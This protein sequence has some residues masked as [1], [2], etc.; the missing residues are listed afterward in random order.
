MPPA[1]SWPIAGVADDRGADDRLTRD[2][3]A[4]HPVAPAVPAAR[5]VPPGPSAGL[6]LGIG[7]T[8]LV[9]RVLR[10]PS[11]VRLRRWSDAHP[12]T[13]DR[14]IVIGAVVL[15][16]VSGAQRLY[17]EPLTAGSVLYFAAVVAVVTG[18]IYWSRRRTRAREERT[19]QVIVDERLRIARE[20]HDVVAHHVSVMGIQAAGARRALETRPADEAV[21]IASGALGEIEASSRTAVLDL[22]RLLGML[23]ASDDQGGV[24]DQPTL[25]QLPVLLDSTRRAGLPVEMTIDGTPPAGGLPPTLDRSAY[26]I[27]QEALTNTLRHAGRGA[28][29][30]IDI[31]YRPRA[32]ELLITDRGG[33]GA[34]DA[35]P[36][37]GNGL[38]GMRERVALFG[39]EFSAGRRP[40]GGF[41]V[42]A[43]LPIEGTGS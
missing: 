26:R 16:A 1:R 2:R 19:R 22:H 23:R 32:L 37:T 36:G 10:L 31:R 3:V 4:H 34:G 15:G 28:T 12:A 41:A 5:A 6:S 8:A 7:M 13:V 17:G 21:T 35:G 43:L 29:A 18:V 30:A 38:V 25:A 14:L 40:E 42:R 20:L 33:S 11:I 24:A 9:A 39:G 27:V